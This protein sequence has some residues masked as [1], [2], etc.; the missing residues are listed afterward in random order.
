MKRLAILCVITPAMIYASSLKEIL[1]FATAKNDIVLSKEMTQESKVLDLES[2]QNSYYPTLDVGGT[3]QSL[4][5]KSRGVAGDISSVYAKIGLDIYDGGKKSALVDKNRAL[6]ESSK[7]DTEAYKKSL[8][9]SITEDFYTIKSTEATL[10]A[11][12]EKNLQLVA[13]LDRIKQFFN[14][15]S[16]TKDEID[17][18]QAE[19]SNNIYLIDATKFQIHSL[20]RLLS[21]KIGRE[22]N[23]LDDTLLVNPQGV[24]KEL[25]DEIKA[26][27]ANALSYNYSAENLLAGYKPQIR[28]EDTFSVYGYGRGDNSYY[29]EGV[30]NQNKLA[31]TFNIKLFDNSVIDKQKESLLV[32]KRAL[33]QQIQQAKTI[34]DINVELASA[35]IQTI[36][37]QIQSAK[38]SLE[39]ATSAYETISEKYKVGVVDNVAYLDALSTKTDA[40]A[41]YEAA[42]NNLQ[43]AYANYYYYTNK[44]IKDY[45]K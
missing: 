2:T 39:S 6:L 23:S 12:E 24:T 40:K 44:N 19:L 38:S 16:A 17:K 45:I 11:Y 26:L 1:E 13:E 5:E 10:R 25:S 3:Y 37:A 20:K 30:D 15:G 35:K 21:V 31:L 43:I 4:N 8:E 32:Q 33:E 22:I 42:L 28:L 41:Q 14:V 27:K 18:L 9:L 29:Y 7:F 34:Q 36:I